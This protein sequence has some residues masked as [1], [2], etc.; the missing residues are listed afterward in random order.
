MNN[1]TDLGQFLFDFAG[2]D[3][4]RAPDR[5]LHHLHIGVDVVESDATSRRRGHPSCQNGAPGRRADRG[6]ED[7]RCPRLASAECGTSR[8]NRRRHVARYLR[9]TSDQRQGSGVAVTRLSLF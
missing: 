4:E 6:C 1:R 2:P 3:D 9:R 7:V 8:E 5:I